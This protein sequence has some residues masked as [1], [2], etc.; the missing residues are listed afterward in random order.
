MS[1]GSVAVRGAAGALLLPA[2]YRA[3]G[4]MSFKI[5]GTYTKGPAFARFALDKSLVFFLM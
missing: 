1:L 3:V 4:Q 2:V 5:A